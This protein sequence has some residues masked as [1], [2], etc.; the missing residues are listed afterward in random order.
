MEFIK[1]NIK[2]I[3]GFIILVVV[4]IEVKAAMK[5]NAAKQQVNKLLETYSTEGSTAYDDRPLNFD[6]LAEAMYIAIRTWTDADEKT[7][8]DILNLVGPA[9]WPKLKNAYNTNMKSFYL[10]S[11]DLK[12]DLNACM[13][14]N[15]WKKVNY[16]PI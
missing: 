12:S 13:D 10:F 16:V 5:R 11:V 8:I 14:D 2:W 1:E 4:Y 7:A 9:G 15:D 6:E 3:L